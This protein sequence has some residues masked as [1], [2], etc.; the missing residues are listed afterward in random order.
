MKLVTYQHREIDA[1][2]ATKEADGVGNQ[3]E[4]IP[5]RSM[6][7]DY[8]DQKPPAVPDLVRQSV[9]AAEKLRLARRPDQPW[10]RTI[11]NLG[12]LLFHL[13]LREAQY[14]RLP[15]SEDLGSLRSQALLAALPK[16][17]EYS[18]LLAGTPITRMIVM[19]HEF[20]P[21]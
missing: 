19:P 1:W 20:A 18:D 2:A 17:L 9:Q 16:T 8:L 3:A 14:L 13:R 21:R 12:N 15:P 6:W 7:A 4:W 11:E 5:T 10:P